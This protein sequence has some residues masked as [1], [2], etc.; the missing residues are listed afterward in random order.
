MKTPP[1]QY[2]DVD[3]DMGGEDG[4][5]ELGGEDGCDS[6]GGSV[7]ALPKKTMA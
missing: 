2:H 4:G 3:P 1:T 7:A 5:K 6:L